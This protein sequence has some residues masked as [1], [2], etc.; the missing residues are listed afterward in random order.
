LSCRFSISKKLQANAIRELAWAVNR[1][2]GLIGAHLLVSTIPYARILE[3]C[4]IPEI[5][6]NFVVQFT[7]D[8]VNLWFAAPAEAQTDGISPMFT[9]NTRVVQTSSTTPGSL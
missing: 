6:G 2:R 5:F 7:I 3:I 1:L 9:H 4:E 8:H